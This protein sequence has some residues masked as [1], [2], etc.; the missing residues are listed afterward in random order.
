MK[1]WL[2]NTVAAA[3]VAVVIIGAKSVGFIG[4]YA[5]SRYAT[6]YVAGAVAGSPGQTGDEV[7][8]N[9]MVSG[10]DTDET[11]GPMYKAFHEEFPSEYQAMT[12]EMKKVLNSGADAE[13]VKAHMQ[14]Y[15]Q[16]ATASL[17][18]TIP[19]APISLQGKVIAARVALYKHLKNQSEDVCGRVVTSGPYDGMP[20]DIDTLRAI[21]GIGTAQMRAA[22]AA[23]R[24]P[25]KYPAVTDEAYSDMSKGM[26]TQGI[27]QS[28]LAILADGKLEAATT[29]DRCNIMIGLYDALLVLPEKTQRE[30]LPDM[31]KP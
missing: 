20:T 10:L 30:L 1:T 4:G 3:G 8:I 12:A 7:Q 29:A 27:T 18:Q 21:G 22:G 9:Q 24:E 16:Q 11:M 23:R 19:E 26:V 14:A 5:A 13:K 28:Q 17:Y 2:K 15:M 6:P 31:L 25:T